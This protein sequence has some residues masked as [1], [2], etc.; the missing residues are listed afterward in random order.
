MDL[1]FCCIVQTTVGGEADAEAIARSLL[2]KRLAACVQIFPVA[3][4]YVWKGAMEKSTEWT[5]AIKARQ[6]DF[7]AIA[8]AIRALHSYELP[9]IVATPIVSGDPA[10]IR[11]IGE[12]T[13]R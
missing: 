12:Q 4:H 11:W 6:Q 8:Q 1:S 7:D 13:S 3:S 10:Y 2:E 9:E 5:L